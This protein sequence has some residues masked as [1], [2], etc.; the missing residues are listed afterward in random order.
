MEKALKR[1]LKSSDADTAF[2][3]HVSGSNQTAISPSYLHT[4]SDLQSESESERRSGREPAPPTLP[5]GRP[6]EPSDRSSLIMGVSGVCE[7]FGPQSAQIG[8]EVA[9]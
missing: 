9:A 3:G 7:N 1:A 6:P 5:G 4:A 2:C 8:M